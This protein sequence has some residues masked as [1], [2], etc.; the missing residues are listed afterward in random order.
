MSDPVVCPI[1]KPKFWCGMKIRQQLG[2][3]GW[4]LTII[5]AMKDE[6]GTPTNRLHRVNRSMLSKFV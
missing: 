2:I 5:G 3:I 6:K 4:N 1:D